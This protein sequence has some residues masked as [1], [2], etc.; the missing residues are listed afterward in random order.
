VKYCLPDVFSDYMFL[1]SKYGVRHTSTRD[2]IN[3]AATHAFMASLGAY[4]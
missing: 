3:D 4:M 2:S 1:R